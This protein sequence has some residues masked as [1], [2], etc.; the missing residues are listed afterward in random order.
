MGKGQQL[1]D[2]EAVSEALT[3]LLAILRTN[4]DNLAVSDVFSSLT[5]ITRLLTDSLAVSDS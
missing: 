5:A 2:R 1:L 3:T 4:A